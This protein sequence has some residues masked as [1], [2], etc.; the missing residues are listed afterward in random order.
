M[1][2]ITI[3]E[4]NSNDK[5]NTRAFM[6]KGEKGEKGDANTLSI[7]TVEETETAS[8]TITGTAPNQTLNL[9]LPKADP[10]T[11]S[12]GTVTKGVDASA[13]ITGDAPN[14]T[15]NLVLPKGDKGDAGAS[16][17]EVPAG[18]VIGWDSSDSIPSGYEEVD[19]PFNY[20][21]TEKKIGTWTN[22]KPLYSKSFSIP[23][24]SNNPDISVAH[25]LSNLDLF[26]ID[27]SASFLFGGNESLSVNWYYSSSDWCRCWINNTNLRVRCTS[28]INGRTTYL[29]V[30]YTK[31]TD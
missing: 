29:T 8:A 30:R 19:N 7:G 10:N 21:T 16:G 27:E 18:S 12:I 25:N 4:G 9:G 6:V 5:D 11:L 28:A 24:E 20:A 3:I 23:I 15:L 2:K 17:Y 31:T 14:Q 13:T 26:W 1:S 22:G